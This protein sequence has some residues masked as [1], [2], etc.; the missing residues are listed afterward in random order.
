M[1]KDR[2]RSLSRV[3]PAEEHEMDSVKHAKQFEQR[4]AFDVLMEAQR[5][6]SGMDRFR[7]ERERNK[8][9][10]NGDQWGDIILV[11]GKSMTEEEYIKGR[12][13]VPLKNN[14]IRRLVRNVLGEYYKQ[15]SEPVCKARDEN[16]QQIAECDNELLKYN[17]QLNRL[18][19]V[20]AR[21]M[22]DYL[23]GAFVIHRKWYGWERDKL[24][25]WTKYVNPK[26]FF[27]DDSMKD[28]RGWD[29]RCLGEVH[30]VDFGEVCGQFA[31]SPEDYRRLRDIYRSASKMSNLQQVCEE[32]GYSRLKNYDFLFTGDPTRCRV[33]EVWRKETKPR[34][35]CHDYNSGEVYKIE[36]SDK[37]VMVDAENAD[38]IARGTAV[39]MAREDIPLIEA[40]WF[41]D[42]YWYYYFLTPFGDILDEGETPFEHKEH[43]YVF[44]AY[45][46]IDGEIHSFVSDVIDQQ[47]YVNRLITMYDWIMRASAKGVLL[48]PEDCLGT[49]TPQEFAEEW[50]SVDG[51]L[52]YNAKPGVPAPQQIANNATNIGIGE[53]L[54]LQL[55]FFEDIS[56]VHGA[57]QGR[58][59]PS[60]ES[61]TLYA[62][63]AMN[64]ATSLLDL[65]I[66][67]NNFVEDAAYKDLKN[68]L[69]FY[70][71]KKIMSIVGYD[72]G[73][74]ITPQRIRD[75]E[76]DIAIAESTASPTF[77]EF[78][79]M[80]LRELV[81]TGLLGLEEALEVGDFPYKDKLLQVIKSREQQLQQGQAAEPIDSGLVQQAQQGVDMDA[82]N[83][84]YGMITA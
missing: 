6:W 79:T 82:V 80:F 26:C 1:A 21:T 62:Q 31:H 28:F 48:V 9:Y 35:R 24:D 40:E 74:D 65:L 23:I 5:Y 42:E 76:I 55:K 72:H 52:F 22:E 69:Q 77:R 44:L 49:H 8:N 2:L 37:Q 34:Y 30:D 17:S 59:G 10:H 18:R 20:N 47:R 75:V 61:G 14:L 45:P 4:R 50:A 41:L 68:I 39:G 12:G 36:V 57:M 29:V 56:G 58:G 78:G 60:G 33:I 46:F 71:D 54:N 81:S 64:A 15:N 70:D 63:Q 53:L 32:F 7:R 13:Q 25:C 83:K 43:P 66:S 51:V 19:M 16:E 3:K 38:R 73:I 27:I 84:A 67:F 11:N